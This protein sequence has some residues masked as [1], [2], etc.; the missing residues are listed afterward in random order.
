VRFAALHGQDCI[1]VGDLARVVPGWAAARY[2]VIDF[3]FDP[4]PGVPVCRMLA[5]L[6]AQF[7]ILALRFHKRNL[8]IRSIDIYERVTFKVAHEDVIALFVREPARELERTAAV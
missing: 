6:P 2:N 7:D 8:C 3:D 5:K 4:A 1:V